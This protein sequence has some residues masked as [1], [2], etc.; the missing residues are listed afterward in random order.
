MAE[1][2]GV[3]ASG[4]A[5]AQLVAG[6]VNGAQKLRKIWCEVRNAPR[7]IE[8]ALQEIELLGQSLLIAQHGLE[9]R[10]Q[11][12]N[13]MAVI[14]GSLKL[15]EEA[16]SNLNAIVSKLSVEAG[17]QFSKRQKAKLKIF[18]QK[19]E[20]NNERERLHRAIRCLTLAISCYSMSIQFQQLDLMTHISSQLPDAQPSNKNKFVPSSPIR[21]ISLMSPLSSRGKLVRKS[22]KSFGVATYIQNYRSQPAL[23]RD[24]SD[25]EAGREDEN[26]GEWRLVPV[27]WSRLNG[28]CFSWT[29]SFGNWQYSLKTIRVV[30]DDSPIFEACATGDILRVIKLLSVGTA[31]L[32]DTNDEGETLLH[33]SGIYNQPEMCKWL[34]KQ[35][36]DVNAWTNTGFTPLHYA[37]L[38]YYNPAK[39]RETIKSL[40]EDGFA[41][42][43]I[44]MASEP[45]STAIHVFHG[46]TEAFSYM[47]AAIQ[48]NHEE[49][50]DYTLAWQCGRCYGALPT[51]YA[52]AAF[53][54]NTISPQR[55]LYSDNE[56]GTQ[57]ALLHAVA[58]NL[59][60]S[61]VVPFD[62]DD[63]LFILNQLLNVKTDLHAFKKR[64]TSPL[65]FSGFK[66]YI[67]KVLICTHMPE[68]KNVFT[69]TEV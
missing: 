31:N 5:V 2:L 35:G 65:C 30:N 68:R 54:K 62:A 46:P 69:Q 67:R 20:I 58:A 7:D 23:W 21:G 25:V 55:A 36:A 49:V 10:G 11:E 42:A 51:S 64:N 61:A 53:A 12:P 19:E 16:A 63:T 44:H 60:D 57:R 59:A 26:Y 41:D 4:I 8:G 40:L 14:E 50:A 1:I 66:H 17:T 39:C 45:L 22:H 27:S 52:R 34:L 47:T 56:I 9:R 3:V 29:K 37:S 15:C 38:A 24:Q 33:V 28:I 32:C 18:L 48:A 6:I 43:S 13:S